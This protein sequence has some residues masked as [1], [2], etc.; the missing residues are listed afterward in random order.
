MR[1]AFSSWRIV[2]N[3]LKVCEIADPFLILYEVA[4]W[5]DAIDDNFSQEDAPWAE[6]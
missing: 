5:H 2:G 1:C 6:K 3:P 4:G